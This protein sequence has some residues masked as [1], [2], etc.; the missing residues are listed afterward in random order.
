MEACLRIRSKEGTLIPF[1]LNQFQKRLVQTVMDSLEQRG[2]AFFVILKGRQLGISTVCRGLMLWR[3]LH[4]PGQQCVVA[5][6]EVGL[7]RQCMSV[8]REMLE[9]LHPALDYAKPNVVSDSRIMWQRSG[10]A[11]LPRLPAGKSEGRG[12]PVNFLHC[13]EADFYDNMQ[14]GTWERFMSG[15]LPALP[16]R[17]AIFIVESTCQGRKALFDLYTKSLQPNSS[18]QHIF[19]PWFEEPQY[20]TD[21]R[22]ELSGRELELQEQYGLTDGQIN[23]WA[24]FS[25]QCGELM[26]LREYPFCIDDAF[27]V[28][29]SSSLILADAV[30][31]SMVRLPWP[32]QEREP[33]V[34]GIDPSRLRDAT[35]FAI[36]QGKNILEVGELP[37]SGDAVELAKTIAEYVRAYNVGP[38]FCDSGGLG[39]AFLDILQRQVGRFVTAIDFSERAQDEKKFANRRA[40]IY[41]R[42]RAWI[43]GGGR[44]PPNQGLAKE[45]LSIEINRRKEGRLLL[46]PK[47]RLTKS[48]NMA[49]ACALTMADGPQGPVHRLFRPIEIKPWN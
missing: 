4:F 26:A 23:F 14:A 44:I 40:E 5:A 34:M 38:I 39:G 18:W 32:L 17:G 8:M 45:L 42:L 29:S 9:N 3:A 20:E 46:E 47:H 43:D 22:Q 36:R 27:S 2:R 10:S 25:R 11:I 12:M 41:D 13:T 1:K 6:H 35:G 31:R 21:A 16:K 19:F 24:N 15:V 28:S 49:D 7:V 48:P 30:E 37:P 33:I